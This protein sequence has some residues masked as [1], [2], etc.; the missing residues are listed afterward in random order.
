M[1]DLH[2]QLPPTLCR[3]RTYG[4]AGVSGKDKQAVYDLLRGRILFKE[5]STFNDPFEGKPHHVAAYKDSGKQ[6]YAME[7]YLA[8]IARER[9][10]S[11]VRKKVAEHLARRSM[12]ELI[13]YLGEVL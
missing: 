7:K 4:A 6:R 12:P 10:M 13:D 8:S 2:S 9:G 5:G 11:S 3:F 1:A